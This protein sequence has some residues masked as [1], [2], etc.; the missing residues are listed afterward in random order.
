MILILED[1]LDRV[2]RFRAVLQSMRP[3]V[4][5]IIWRQAWKMIAEVEGYLPQ[6]TIISLDHD[7]EPNPEDDTDPG[8]GVEV[9]K[10]LA[11]F[12][13]P[14]PVIIH[15]SNGER[16]QWMAGEFDLEGWKH[17]RVLPYDD[18][19]IE[20]HWRRA[21]KRLLRRKRR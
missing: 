16:A 14:C 17:H 11:Q 15:T 8:D 20:R 6:A 19:W 1:S 2:A 3:E 21:V 5:I 13:Q 4:S 18:E 9:A 10:F 12:S 7:L